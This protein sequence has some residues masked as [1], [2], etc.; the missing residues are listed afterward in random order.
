MVWKITVELFNFFFY[1]TEKLLIE[2]VD[3]LILMIV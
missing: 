1:K 3:I 2:F